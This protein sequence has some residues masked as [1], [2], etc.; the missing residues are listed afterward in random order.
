[1]LKSYVGI[2]LVRALQA[3]H[4][5]LPL[6]LVDLL[7]RRPAGWRERMATHESYTPRSPALGR[8]TRSV[9]A[10]PGQTTRRFPG[11]TSKLRSKHAT[12]AQRPVQMLSLATA[13][14]HGRDEKHL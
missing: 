9:T 5:W 10:L 1:M 14:E 2:P 8:V 3:S 4:V 6:V 11:Q 13:E 12:F 7:A